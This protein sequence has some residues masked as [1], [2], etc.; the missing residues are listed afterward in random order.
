MRQPPLNMGQGNVQHPINQGNQPMAATLNP[1][2]NHQ[3]NTRPPSLQG[4]MN[5]PAMAGMAPNINPD[6]AMRNFYAKLQQDRAATNGFQGPKPG[7]MSG[8]PGPSQA[9]AMG[10]PNQAGILDP[11]QKGNGAMQSMGQPGAMQQP[12]QLPGGGDQQF[13]A[14]AQTPHGRAAMSNMDVPPPV[15]AQFRGIIP[16]ET[17][18]WAQLRQFLQANP[19]VAPP[20]LVARLNQLQISQFKQ[21]WDRRPQAAPTIAP[22]GPSGPIPQQPGSQPQALP[23]GYSYPPN[24]AQVSRQDI[25]SARRNPQFQN[26]SDEAL[27]DFVR[28]F[29]RDLMARKAWDQYNQSQQ[30]RGNM[31]LPGGP[32]KPGVQVSQSPANQ[33]AGVTAPPK[34]SPMMGVQH[35]VAQPKPVTTPAA[36][37]PPAPAKVARPPP[38][39]PSP[40]TAAKNLKRP[41]SDD[42]DDAAGQPGGAVQRQPE[43]RPAPSGPKPTLEQLM[44]LPPEQLAR[45][46]PEQLAKLTPEQQRA[47]TM[48]IRQVPPAPPETVAR[49][50][51]LAF[52]GHRLA[53]DELG[54][55]E[56]QQQGAGITM[57]PA[58]LNE[59]R[60]KIIQASEKLKQIRAGIARW[61]HQTKDD[62][63]ARMYF[64]IV[65]ASFTPIFPVVTSFDIFANIHSSVPRWSSSSPTPIACLSCRIR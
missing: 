19:G 57:S 11:N 23:P 25:D 29:K 50:K 65:R 10:G 9:N 40:S 38:P 35:Q 62:S 2:F 3:N 27:V 36:D 12:K 59:T 26:M 7:M 49:L 6:G 22:Q 32:Q 60:A 54:R 56:A 45:I 15:L 48:R 1:Q 31:N 55:Q 44:K 51:T 34:P 37:V 33:P 4:N 64:K 43:A 47:I 20:Q 18:R 42:A 21:T 46:S 28:K 17:R 5:N 8:I 30:Q 61:Y 53:I 63:R 52:E 13:F 39:N 16:A 41:H 14:Y 24:I 58:A